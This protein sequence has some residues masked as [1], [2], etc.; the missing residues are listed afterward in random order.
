MNKINLLYI[1]DNVD[2]NI[3]YYLS[4]TLK[5]ENIEILNNEIE[6]KESLAYEGLLKNQKVKDADIILI[7]S[8][9]FENDNI[10]EKTFTGEEFKIIIKKIFPYKEIIVLS[11]NKD[12]EDLQ[13]INKFHDDCQIPEAEY[14]DKTLKPVIEEAKN[15]ILLYRKLSDKLSKNSTIEKLLFERIKNSLSGD[16]EYDTLNK[17]DI[18]LLISE[19]RK[20]QAKYE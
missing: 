20:I 6:F 13:I 19:F 4:T 10:L 5:L 9:L 12:D 8:K 15:D 14:Y 1:D 17:A 3:S 2:P 7:D 16:N 11:Q 18:D